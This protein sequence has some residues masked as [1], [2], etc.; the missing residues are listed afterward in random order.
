MNIEKK[1]MC[2]VL[3]RSKSDF[4]LHNF[5]VNLF[6][7]AQ[8]VLDLIHLRCR[9]HILL[10]SA[11]CVSTQSGQDRWCAAQRTR[12]P[13]NPV[14]CLC[15]GSWLMTASFFLTDLSYGHKSSVAMRLS[16]S[17]N[18]LT[19]ASWKSWPGCPGLQLPPRGSYRLWL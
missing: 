16:L 19:S 3:W 12:D 11:M 17:Q 8:P 6:L 1:T 9:T 13:L 7:P 14:W 18:L 15:G 4:Y 10:S 2:E 5:D